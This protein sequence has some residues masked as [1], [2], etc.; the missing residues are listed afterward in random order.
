MAIVIDQDV[1]LDSQ[2]GK[3]GLRP[4]KTYSLEVPVDH[5]LAVNVD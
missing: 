5:S 4:S 2:Q 3:A 1:S